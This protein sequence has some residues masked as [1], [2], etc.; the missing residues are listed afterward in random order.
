MS[1]LVRAFICLLWA[2]AISFSVLI[3][4]QAIASSVN[5]TSL[6]QQLIKLPIAFE[7]NRGQTGPSV[8]FLARGP[9]YRLFLATNEAVM[10]YEANLKS[11]NA[12]DA[13]VRMRFKGA[14]KSPVI[15]GME[16]LETKTNYFIGGDEKRDITDV[17]N[18]AKVK[19]TGLYP[20][21]D[22]EYYGN[23]R[24]Q[25]EYDFIVAPRA[26][27][28][29]IKFGF[30]GAK[31]VGIAANGD[32]VL[33]TASGEVVHHKP[34]AYQDIQGTRK[35]V[36][37]KYKLIDAGRFI[38][39]NLGKYDVMH[40]LVID[41]IVSYSSNLWGTTKA[42][43]LD[44]SGNIYV[45]GYTT[46]ADLPA[47][48]GYKKTLTGTQDAYVVKLD[49]TGT[50]VIY[51]TYLGARR[52]YTTG[53]SIAVDAAGNAYLAGQTNSS[54]FP[55]T[56]GAYE[57][58]YSSN[59]SFVTKLNANGNALVYSTFVNGA[60]VGNIGTSA[61]IRAI[62]VDGSGNAF[63]TGKG[64]IPTTAGAFQTT[65]PN[66]SNRPI[67]VAK[68]N[69][70]GSAMAYATYL[71]GTNSE[72]VSALAIDSFG[73]AH[74]TGWTDSSDFPL[75]N[76]AQSALNGRDAFV[77][78]L[79][80]AGSALV[81]STYLG[82]VELEE[83]NG[84]A[85]DTAGNAYVVGRT[86][87]SNFLVTQGAF[88]PKKGYAGTIASNGFLTKFSPTGTVIYSSYLG[89][90]FCS[91]TL[92]TSEDAATT[93]AVDAAGFAYVGGFTRSMNFPG[94]DQIN[95]RQSDT[96]DS[97]W[98]MPFAAKVSPNGDRLVYLAAIGA[99]AYGRQAN[100]IAVNA[101]GS[102]HLVGEN[103]EGSVA[104]PVTTGAQLYS[105][106]SFLIKLDIGK[107]PTT[108]TSYQSPTV[109]GQTV[110]LMVKVQSPKAGGTVHFMDGATTLGTV[111]PENGMATFTTT[112][113]QAGVHKITAVY[114]GDGK[115]SP[116]FYQVVNS[117]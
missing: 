80:A 50:K 86:E 28:D 20:G 8:K 15:Q 70:N 36:E 111:A 65:N 104:H 29:S 13:I 82:G 32:L 66:S 85:T 91:C 1:K 117:R 43:A 68:L 56:S 17:P 12:K 48:N 16:S 35:P 76:S 11:P 2:L 9:G 89:G 64:V 3:Y 97:F 24:Q 73:N 109:V 14:N 79:N 84:I 7:E 105:G 74:I 58:R 92:Y 61:A 67:F 59:A 63:I 54:A 45:A 110:T 41:P 47:I 113:L 115:V 22:L 6:H 112:N 57:T 102:A 39:F 53:N 18:H 83:G 49:P 78:K 69:A 108:V 46:S 95:A 60:E 107:Y 44:S 81:Y 71:G 98:S 106:S 51:G 30:S 42:I 21:I 87:S 99:R 10:A 114:S 55:V 72:V 52:A 62:A 77:A 38:A 4:P 5:S 75:A 31:K 33:K 96:V 94:V 27:P 116:P 40:T 90:Q 25:L 100:G 93:V 37:V 101:D 34:V 88:Q 19:Y 103:G 23:Q 26:S